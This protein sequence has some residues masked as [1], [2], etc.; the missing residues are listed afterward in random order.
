M[1][2]NSFHPG[3]FLQELL[4]WKKVEP[5]DLAAEI[6]IPEEEIVDITEQ[7]RAIDE[8]I[9]EEL[10]EYFGNSARFWMHLQKTYDQKSA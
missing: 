6:G 7:R 10:A 1:S 3:V 8:T 4:I 2:E 9:S 5:A